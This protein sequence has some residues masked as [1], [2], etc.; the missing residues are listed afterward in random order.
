MPHNRH[1]W[2]PDTYFS[3]GHDVNHERRQRT[4]VEPTGYVRSS[5]MLLSFCSNLK[6]YKNF[7]K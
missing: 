3:N 7:S 1:I 4:V 5:E 6:L 2:I